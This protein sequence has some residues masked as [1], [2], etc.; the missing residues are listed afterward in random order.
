MSFASLFA[1]RA[2]PS[3]T[4]RRH[5]PVRFQQHSCA[6]TILLLAHRLDLRLHQV[7]E[8]F[9]ATDGRSLRC[10]SKPRSESGGGKPFLC[11]VLPGCRC[12]SR[13]AHP[14]AQRQTCRRRRSKRATKS[15][16]PK[17]KSPT[18]AWPHSMS[19]TKRTP[20]HSDPAFSLSGAVAAAVVVEAAVAAEA[21]AVGAAAFGAAPAVQASG[22]VSAWGVRAALLSPVQAAEDVGAAAVCR[23]APVVTVRRERAV[24]SQVVAGSGRGCSTVTP[25]PSVERCRR[26]NAPR[27]PT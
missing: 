15:F 20:V 7:S 27:L 18:S 6:L 2:R 11:W 22:A 16:S 8:Q 23:G 21:E 9:F 17:R 3:R 24:A 19:S 12:R 13:A 5:N 26:G 10:R 14:V 1:E 25:T 4:K